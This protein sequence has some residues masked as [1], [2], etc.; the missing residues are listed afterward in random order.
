[1]SEAAMKIEEPTLDTETLFGDLRDAILDRLKAMPKPWTV[2][3]ENEQRDL[4]IGVEM[5]TRHLINSAVTLIA[6]NGHPTIK[7]TLA[8][9]TVKDGIKAVLQ[10]SMH[11][12]MR[13]ELMDAVGKPVV[14]VVAEVAQF[15]GEKSPAKPDPQEPA[16]PLNSGDNVKPLKPKD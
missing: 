15:L 6:A 1:M 9:A 11:D 7:A 13:H 5:A 8:S 10:M 14:V 3:S 12:P 16:L 2:M 4:I